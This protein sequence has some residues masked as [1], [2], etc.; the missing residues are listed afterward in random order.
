MSWMTWEGRLFGQMWNSLNDFANRLM[1][2]L[3]QFTNFRFYIF[4]FISDVPFI[5][6]TERS[7]IFA[8]LVGGYWTSLRNVVWMIRH[9]IRNFLIL[10]DSAWQ[11]FN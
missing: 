4:L 8:S 10:N 5:N 11:L 1:L 6:G 7:P 3:S 9:S 2:G